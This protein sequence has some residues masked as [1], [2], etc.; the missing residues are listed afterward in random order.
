MLVKPIRREF[1]VALAA[2]AGSGCFGKFA[3]TNALY[4][5]NKDVSDNKWLRW[6]VFLVLIILPVYGLF[7]IADALVINTIEFFTG[8]NPIGGGHAKLP[9]GHTLASTRTRDPNVIRHEHRKNGELVQVVYVRRVSD[10][11]LHLANEQG[12][13]LARAK[14][15]ADGAIEIYDAEGKLVRRAGARE[16]ERIGALVGAGGRPSEALGIALDPRAA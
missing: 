7:I 16:Q 8:N 11:E 1:L 15:A 6:L 5:W 4:D 13:L 2:L 14:L 10:H 12:R 3:A 9:E